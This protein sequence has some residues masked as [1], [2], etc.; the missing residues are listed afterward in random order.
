[1]FHLATLVA[2]NEPAVRAKLCAREVVVK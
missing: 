1:V 2:P